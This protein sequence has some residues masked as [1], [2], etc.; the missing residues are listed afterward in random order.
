MTVNP[1]RKVLAISAAVLLIAFN[2]EIDLAGIQGTGKKAAVMGPI[3]SFGSIF[4]DGVEYTTSG[5]NITIDDQPGSEAQLRA[6][7]IVTIDGTVNDD[8]TTGTATTVSF[9]GNA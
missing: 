8:G 7:Q 1:T 6:G 9:T 3:T 2:S 4:L 5:A